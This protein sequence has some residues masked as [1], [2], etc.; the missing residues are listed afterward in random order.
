MFHVIGLF[1]EFF[2]TFCNT[3]LLVHVSKHVGET[4]K[5][6]GVLGALGRKLNLET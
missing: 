6:K 4:E 2:A 1:F 5:H 3:P